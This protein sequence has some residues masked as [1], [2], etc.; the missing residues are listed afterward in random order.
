MMFILA[1]NDQS[2]K[3]DTPFYIL[4]Q[5]EIVAWPNYPVFLLWPVSTRPPW[6]EG[7]IRIISWQK[8]DLLSS[9]YGFGI[10]EDVTHSRM[11]KSSII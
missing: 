5:D 3:W 7:V 4:Q 11:S 2:I 8:S 9:P 1:Y 10:C 6:A